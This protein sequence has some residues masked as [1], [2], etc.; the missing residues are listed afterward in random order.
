MFTIRDPK[1]PNL[2]LHVQP[3]AAG[4]N[5]NTNI[6][7]KKH[8]P[9][10]GGTGE[11]PP[12]D[13]EWGDESEVVVDD[14]VPPS[15]PLVVKQPPALSMVPPP[16]RQ[17][18]A[19]DMQ[20]FLAFAKQ[21]M[22]SYVKPLVIFA[23]N[24]RAKL[25]L[26]DD[27]KLLN[28]TQPP[29][30]FDVADN[31]E[32]FK[33]IHGLRLGPAIVDALQADYALYQEAMRNSSSNMYEYA[34]RMALSECKYWTALNESEVYPLVLSATFYGALQVACTRINAQVV[35]LHAHIHEYIT[36]SDG[37]RSMFQNVVTAQMQE[38]P[39]FNVYAIKS[40]TKNAPNQYALS[41]GMKTRE[42]RAHYLDACN[43]WF[44]T[45]YR[46]QGIH[47]RSA[48]LRAMVMQIPDVQRRQAYI[49]EIDAL[50]KA[51]SMLNRRAFNAN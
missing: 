50:D 49:K 30:Y 27:R 9:G 37:V 11:P 19:W 2:I 3:I 45:V 25:G 16:P 18:F 40:G 4:G 34:L 24:M 39:G 23:A 43:I 31:M 41:A 10:H 33:F 36:A 38:G 21:R 7:P 46:S 12:S 5:N 47:W 35:H 51:S 15:A 14:S 26:V 1:N 22:A 32:T 44:R 48:E 42:H 20:A 6:T 13:E 8:T 28:Y 17:P 29:V